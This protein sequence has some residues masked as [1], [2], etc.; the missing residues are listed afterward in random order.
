MYNLAG[1]VS[2]NLTLTDLFKQI[3]LHL[4][5]FKFQTEMAM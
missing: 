2:F 5:N 4:C 3:L 1:N